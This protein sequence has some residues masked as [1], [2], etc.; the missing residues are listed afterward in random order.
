MFHG[1]VIN[2][3]GRKGSEKK[4]KKQMLG[5]NSVRSLGGNGMITEIVGDEV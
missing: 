4:A 5:K 3:S 2:N 1:F